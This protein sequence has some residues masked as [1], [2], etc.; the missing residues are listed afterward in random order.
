MN[1]R[2]L[3][4]VDEWRKLIFTKTIENDWDVWNEK[5][6]SEQ[7]Y[8]LESIGSLQETGT[9]GPAPGVAEEGS[10]E[11]AYGIEEFLGGSFKK[12]DLQIPVL[13][14]AT[15]AK[16][17]PSQAPYDVMPQDSDPTSQGPGEK[18]KLEKIPEKPSVPKPGPPKAPEV[19]KRASQESENGKKTEEDPDKVKVAPVS[20]PAANTVENTVWMEEGSQVL[21]FGHFVNYTYREIWSWICGGTLTLSGIFQGCNMIDANVRVRISRFIDWMHRLQQAIDARGI[22]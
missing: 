6:S 3:I 21:G 11:D 20:I 9:L 5:E 15:N 4:T 18:K 7:W 10:D 1:Q 8:A 16:P 19:V 17:G 22:A 12:L 2:P 13:P 14:P